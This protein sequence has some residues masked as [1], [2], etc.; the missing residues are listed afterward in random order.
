[1]FCA[2]QAN[3]NTRDTRCKQDMRDTRNTRDMRCK[4]DTRDMRDTRF[5][6]DM[7][8]KRNERNRRNMRDMRNTQCKR[9]TMDKRSWIKLHTQFPFKTKTLLCKPEMQA[10]KTR[11]TCSSATPRACASCAVGTSK[12]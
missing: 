1:M 4:Q 2:V 8:D 9:D 6:Q 7:R 5:K 12:Q 3:R 11:S 10:L